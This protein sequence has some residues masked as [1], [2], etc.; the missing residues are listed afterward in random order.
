ML[1]QSELKEEIRG[2]IKNEKPRQ[3]SFSLGDRNGTPLPLTTA[4]RQE[5]E[6]HA[7]VFLLI[8]LSGARK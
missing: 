8:D 3:V 4:S 5:K 1:Y 6:F 7:A 2:Q